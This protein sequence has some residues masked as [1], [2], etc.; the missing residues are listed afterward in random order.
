MT[1]RTP[2]PAASIEEIA[3]AEG[4]TVSAVTMCLGRALKKLRAQGLLITCRELAKALDHGR[5]TENSV[6]PRSRRRA[7]AE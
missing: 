2:K 7:G 4:L 3:Q 1:R 6:R 5:A